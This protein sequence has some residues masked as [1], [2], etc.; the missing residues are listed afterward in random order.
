[1]KSIAAE[2][3]STDSCSY[4]HVLRPN[5]AAAATFLHTPEC[6]SDAPASR[7]ERPIASGE[8]SVVGADSSAMLFDQEHRG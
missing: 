3:A 5:L 7:K 1:M 8:A 6:Q 2:A 4:R